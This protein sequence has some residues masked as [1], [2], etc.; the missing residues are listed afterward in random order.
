MTGN[1]KEK[2]N[3]FKEKLLM[4]FWNKFKEE[5]NREPSEQE[6]IDNLAQDVENSNGIDEET[7]TKFIERMS[8]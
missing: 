8:S 3:E 6:M 1:N 7:I 2:V 4:T 5:L